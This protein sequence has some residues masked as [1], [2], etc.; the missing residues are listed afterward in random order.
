MSLARADIH[1]HTTCSDG[2]HTPVELARA[3]GYGDLAVAAITDHD[4]IEGGLR[5]RDVLGGLGPEIIVGSE[6]TS[7]DGHVLGLFLGRD[8]P[9]GM[10]AEATIAAIHE[11][12]GVAIA[13][14]P[15]ALAQGVGDRAAKLPFD[16]I[17]VVNGSPL[18]E[19]GNQRARHRLRHASAALLGG[20]DAHVA[21]AVGGVYT[22]FPG[23]TAA[24]LRAAISA[25]RTEPVTDWAVHLSS[26][27]EHT[28]WLGWLFVAKRPS[29]KEPTPV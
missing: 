9:A 21:G 10:S 27:T 1:I 6:I 5:V 14:H 3:L 25:R 28:A 7:A 22:R 24:D 29:V 11:Q 18:M 23:S 8:V 17:E 20:S 12:G 26:M 19:L 15:Y 13:A 4:T 16:G 2:R